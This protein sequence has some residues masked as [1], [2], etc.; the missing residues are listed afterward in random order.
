MVL[1]FPIK[2]LVGIW[3]I[4]AALFFMPGAVRNTLGAIK[5][6]LNRALSAM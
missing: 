3:L 5:A 2:I 4:G 6:G 1:G